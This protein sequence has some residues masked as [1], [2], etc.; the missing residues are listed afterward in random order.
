MIIMGYESKKRGRAGRDKPLRA[1]AA[2]SRGKRIKG[3]I[4]GKSSWF[5]KSSS[6][7]DTSTTSFRKGVAKNKKVRK[8]EQPPTE[9]ILF[10]DNTGGGR[11][12][13]QVRRATRRI[14]SF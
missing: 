7:G 6:R 13:I 8:Q 10:V 9:S 12:C 3:K 14:E 11:T 2:Q 1:T 4:I 5:K